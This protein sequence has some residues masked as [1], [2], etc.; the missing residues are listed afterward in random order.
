MLDIKT[1]EIK[2]IASESK[3]NKNS[4]CTSVIFKKSYIV[5]DITG[6]DYKNRKMYIYSYDGKVIRKVNVQPVW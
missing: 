6:E 4:A 2:K 3:N 1:G 5:I